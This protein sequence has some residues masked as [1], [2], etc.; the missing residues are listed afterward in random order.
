MKRQLLNIISFLIAIIFMS[1]TNSNS[2]IFS[3]K[4]FVF[5]DNSSSNPGATG[6]GDGLATIIEAKNQSNYT[7]LIGPVW[8]LC[9]NTDQICAI[10]ADWERVGLVLRPKISGQLIEYQLMQYFGLFSPA[11]PPQDPSIVDFP[12]TI[13]EKLLME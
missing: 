10:C 11:L 2:E 6:N 4:W 13:K 5:D 12:A 3:C 9:P 7:E 8:L 1:Y